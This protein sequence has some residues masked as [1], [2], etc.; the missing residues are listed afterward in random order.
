MASPSTRTLHP[1][2]RYQGRSGH[3]RVDGV[4]ELWNRQIEHALSRL[5]VDDGHRKGCGIIARQIAEFAT[6]VTK[7]PRWDRMRHERLY[8]EGAL[9]KK[10][11]AAEK[12]P[13]SDEAE[14]SKLD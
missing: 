14:P 8:L 4:G 13:S 2:G 3:S 12:L 11:F 5:D 6:F 7:L 1:S 10:S 9:Q